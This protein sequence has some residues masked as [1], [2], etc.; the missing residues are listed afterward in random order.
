MIRKDKIM[1]REER[2]KL[3]R[4]AYQ[5]LIQ[6]EAAWS[7]WCEAPD[8]FDPF[9]ASQLQHQ[10]KTARRRLENLES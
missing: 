5:D 1:T 3:I 10:L 2:T 4:E 8:P 9:G 6:A 7:A